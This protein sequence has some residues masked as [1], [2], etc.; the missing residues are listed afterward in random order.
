MIVAALCQRASLRLHR[1][2]RLTENWNQKFPPKPVCLDARATA[3]PGVP[4]L[5]EHRIVKS[6]LLFGLVLVIGWNLPAAVVVET[7]DLTPSTTPQ[8]I[9][10]AAIAPSIT[11]EGVVCVAVDVTAPGQSMDGVGGAFNELGWNALISL[12]EPQRAEVLRNLFDTKQGAAL[13][14]NRIPIGASDFATNAYSLDDV[15]NDWKLKHFSIKRDEGCLIPYIKAA[16][17]V[18]PEMKFH[19]SPWSPPA[20]MKTNGKLT[21]GQLKSDDQTLKSHAAYFVKFLEAYAKHGI[22]ISRLCPQN[23]PVNATAYPSCVVPGPL[24]AEAVTEWI[25][26]AVRKSRLHTEV[27]AGTLNYYRPVDERHFETLL[28]DEQMNQAIGGLSFQY[29]HLPWLREYH[30][31]YPHLPIQMS[32]SECYN[33]NNSVDQALRDFQDFVGYTRTGCQLFTFWNM[34]L[35]EPRKSSWHW[36]Q[37]SL[38]VID[39]QT[40]T[41]TYEPSFALARFLGREI[42]PGSRYLPATVTTKDDGIGAL[43]ILPKQFTFLQS[44]LA[45]GEQVVAFSRSGG[46]FV[47]ILLNQGPPTRAQVKAG[48]KLFDATLPA[49]SLCGIV[50][51][52]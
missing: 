13:R 6:H 8:E 23:E 15:T 47:V 18:N 45:G 9:R 22:I 37:N 34:V 44:N 32:E 50:V 1:L 19:A 30:A 20:W 24:Y 17:A 16:Q 31:R 40:Q 29:T 21:G 2:E 25:V 33:G 35:A 51:D 49:A 5:E 52:Q 4:D 11:N 38:V 41:V 7:I 42:A 48:G 3:R 39:K 10:V 36:R 43:N 26:P 46:G 27:W 28:A 14:F 12:P